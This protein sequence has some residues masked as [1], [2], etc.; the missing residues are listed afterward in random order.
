MV[1]ASITESLGRVLTLFPTRAVA[2]CSR[3]AFVAAPAATPEPA[4]LRRADPACG[5]GA[6]WNRRTGRT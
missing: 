5:I 4:V 1:L 2:A 6:G 3:V